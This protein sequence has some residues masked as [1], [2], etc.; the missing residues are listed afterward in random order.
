MGKRTRF[1]DYQDKYANFHFELSDEGILL[2]R[3]HTD[4]GPLVWDAESHDRMADA[5]A[6]IAGDREIKVVI[7]TG[8]GQTTTPT[9]VSWPK[10]PPMPTRFPKFRPDSS[11]PWNSWT[12]AAG[13]DA[14]SS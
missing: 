3:C 8:T 13:M 6:D 5:F 7:H 1:H 10:G 14:C 12:N 11:H 2:M 9:G 4:N